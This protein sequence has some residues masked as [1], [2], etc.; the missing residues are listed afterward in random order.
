MKTI[1][2]IWLILATVFTL[3]GII[4]F[5]LAMNLAGWDFMKLS[6]DKFETETYEF[7]DDFENI[8]VKIDTAHIKFL[9]S[10]TENAKV[11]CKETKKEKHEVSVNDG[12]LNI[13][14][15]DKRHWT[16][17]ISFFSLGSSEITVYLPKTEYS[18]IDIHTATGDMEIPQNFKFRNI[19]IK[20]STAAVKCLAS[21]NEDIKIA[22]ST[23][24]IS[25]SDLSARN[26]DLACST[27]NIK[28][29]NITC[30]DDINL[31]VTTGK[32]ALT[33]INCKNLISEGDT[34]D[35][36][37]KEVSAEEKFNILRDTGDV[38]LTSCDAEEIE[39]ETDTGDIRGTLK[40]PKIFI[41]DT[42]TGR[43]DVPKSTEG[44]KC[45]I[46]TDTGDIK[47]TI[48]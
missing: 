21:A 4:V 44:G 32:T 14:L 45:E 37:L 20:G 48:E 41:T 40:T 16:D 7:Q 27:G 39:I 26:L 34:G 24:S 6:T 43:I 28:I 23:G 29:N 13:L 25:L 35:L 8:S 36:I 12:T 18:F 9:P 19:Q 38:R 46:T 17:Y 1:N 15:K 22:L 42:D 33:N 30:E 47:I 11:I 31:I 5:T 10:D 2:K 3:S